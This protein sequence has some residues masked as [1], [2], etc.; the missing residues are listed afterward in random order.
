MLGA[1]Q[2]VGLIVGAYVM[3]RCLEVALTTGGN[4]NLRKVTAISMIGIALVI[5]VI[6]AVLV[7]VL[8]LYKIPN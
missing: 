7:V 4:P 1:I 6:E 8:I 2:L 3:M 5:G